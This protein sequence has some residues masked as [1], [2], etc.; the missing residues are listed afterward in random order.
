[1]G[2]A[3][4]ACG[5]VD[6]CKADQT[7]G[8]DPAS[9]WRVYVSAAEISAS[10]PSGAGWDSFGGA[11]DT[12]IGLWCPASNQ[13]LGAIMPVI[14]DDYFPVWSGGGCTATAAEFLADGVGFDALDIDGTSADDEISPFTVAPVTEAQ[15]RAGTKTLTAQS[16]LDE[17][18]FRFVKQ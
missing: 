17:I 2:A 5:T 12:E 3:C 15:L 9:T 1:M 4:S 10:K 16:S 11:P 18:T 13:S 7:C 6:V 14:D 8:I